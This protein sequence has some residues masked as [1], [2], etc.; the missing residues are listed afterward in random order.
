M[1]RIIV[2]FALFGASLALAGC[3]ETV[4]ANGPALQATAPVKVADARLPAGAACTRE[5]NH[6][7]T[8][9]SADLATGNVEQGVYDKIE[10]DLDRAAQ[11]CAAG[12]GGEAHAIVAGTKNAH[13]YRG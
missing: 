5:I 11:A 2:P 8:I 1:M 4:A 3:N 6:F 12:R 7:Q 10:A 9:L 13:G